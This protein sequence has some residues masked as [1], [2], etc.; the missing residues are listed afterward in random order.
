MKKIRPIVISVITFLLVVSSFANISSIAVSQRQTSGTETSTL[1]SYTKNEEIPANEATSTSSEEPEISF[2]EDTEQEA[3]DIKMPEA[4]TGSEQAVNDRFFSRVAGENGSET[5]FRKDDELDVSTNWL[6]VDTQGYNLNIQMNDYTTSAATRQV[7]IDIPYGVMIRRTQLDDIAGSN[8]SPHVINW[9]IKERNPRVINQ[10]DT[11]FNESEFLDSSNEDNPYNTSYITGS[12]IVIELDP[13]FET[14][15]LS[16]S[17]L[18]NYMDTGHDNRS[19]WSGVENSSLTRGLPLTIEMFEDDTSVEK[20]TLDDIN[21]PS[22]AVASVVTGS[23]PGSGQPNPQTLDTDLSI[24]NQ[25]RLRRT[26]ESLGRNAYYMSNVSWQAYVPYK[27]LGDG[28]YVSAILDGTRMQAWI[29]RLTAAN[30]KPVLTYSTETQADGR[31]IVNYSFADTSQEYLLLV[32]QL[33]MHYKLPSEA[34]EPDPSKNFSTSDK[35]LFTGENLGWDF[36]NYQADEDGN[37]NMERNQVWTLGDSTISVSIKGENMP[38]DFAN[39]NPNGISGSWVSTL[40]NTKGQ[41]NLLGFNLIK[42]TTSGSGT[43]EVNYEFGTGTPWR[44]GVT[45]VQFWTVNT[46]YGGS[47]ASAREYPYNF[48]FKLQ[49]KGSSAGQ[50]VLEGEYTLIPSQEYAGVNISR[51]YSHSV[52]GNVNSKEVE[53]LL[54]YPDERGFYYVNREMLIKGL[55]EVPGDIDDYYIKS[56]TY[57]LAITPTR[58]GGNYTSGSDGQPR[59]NGGNFFGETFQTAGGNGRPLTTFSIKGIEGTESNEYVNDGIRTQIITDS[60]VANQADVSLGINDMTVKNDEDRLLTTTNDR[61]AVGERVNVAAQAFHYF[62]PYAYGQYSPDPVFI[63]RTPVDMDL[64]PSTIGLTQDGEALTYDLS[65]P[66]LL[67]EN[68]VNGKVYLVTPQTEKGI[69]YYNE[70]RETIGNNIKINYQ[71]QVNISARAE[72]INY[73]ELLFITDKNL[74][75]GYAGQ[76]LATMV[77]DRWGVGEAISTAETAEKT[78]LAKIFYYSNNDPSQ[79]GYR[80]SGANNSGNYMFNTVQAELD[81]GLRTDL[82]EEVPED[83]AGIGMLDSNETAFDMNF[84]MN[85]T[86]QPGYVVSPTGRFFYY[87]PIPKTTADANLP[88]W[89]DSQQTSQYSLKLNGEVSIESSANVNYQVY[90]STDKNLLYN[91]GDTSIGGSASVARYVPYEDVQNNL[92]DVTMVKVVAEVRGANN[93]LV[94]YGEQ[95]TASLPVIYDGSKTEFDTK[96]KEL[97]SWQPYLIQRYTLDGATNEFRNIAPVKQVRI[98]YRE[99]FERDIYAFNETDYPNWQTENT[100]RIQTVDL[101]DFEN[102]TGSNLQIKSVET[103]SN[104]DLETKNTISNNLNNGVTYGNRT[105]A[106]DN[107]FSGGSIEELASIN[108][109]TSIGNISQTGNQLNYEIFNT[110]NINNVLDA[111]KVTITYQSK[112]SDDLEFQVVLNIRR[113]LSKITPETALVAGK[114]YSTITPGDATTT[115]EDGAFTVQFAYD[116]TGVNENNVGA[117]IGNDTFLSFNKSDGST[118]AEVNLPAGATILMKN[119]SRKDGEPIDPIY[120]YYRNDT[121]SPLT[122]VDLT[123]FI[124]TGT[125]NETLTIADMKNWAVDYDQ[126][127][128]LFIIDFGQGNAPITTSDNY[129]SLEFATSAAYESPS[130][131]IN[132]ERIFT[133]NQTEFPPVSV[134]QNEALNLGGS[135]DVND[136][137]GSVDAFNTDKSVAMVIDLTSAMNGDTVNWPQGTLLTDSE[138]EI[139]ETRR[140]GNQLIFIYPLGDLTNAGAL[141][142]YNFKITTPVDPLPVGF[143]NLNLQIKTNYEGDYPLNGKVVNTISG[144]FMIAQQPSTGL[145][146]T[147]NLN[148]RLLYN[149]SS[150]RDITLNYSKTN[151]S[152]VTAEVQVKNGSQYKVVEDA[153]RDQ[154]FANLNPILGAD[155]GSWNIQIANDLA[156]SLNGEYQIVFNAYQNEADTE[157]LYQVPWTFMIWDPPEN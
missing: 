27:D 78:D 15:G 156:Q 44:M 145:R 5:Y 157:P 107:G 109:I 101:P 149:S 94:P 76:N 127:S 71:M 128:Y 131:N 7:E 108:G 133:H 85:N 136:V 59:N 103:T 102:L 72:A 9:S 86:S 69:G 117:A 152:K 8:A 123:K 31:V 99:I 58:G 126:L 56:L 132:S 104:V 89:Y 63:I 13:S 19:Y 113:R 10:M 77:P 55:D 106:I 65:D 21:M 33:E 81:F 17:L 47:I 144:A 91:S 26:N 125:T 68:G 142:E 34:K 66:I 46:D 50:N 84:S 111:R 1:N 92:A 119:Q 141:F 75:S 53:P 74:A 22:P 130:Y 16:L 42:E 12:K 100:P 61:V 155:T 98:R 118:S 4:K 116:V 73:Q 95:M 3:A 35:I 41:Q 105:F 83:D 124:R 135:L 70:D 79:T 39:L 151:I 6:G 29:D 147:S 110:N 82:S 93:T 60:F 96:A 37:M 154:I 2:E 28:T 122:K 30:G 40:T 45:T 80:L 20:R 153:V 11:T 115:L 24:Y 25:T 51:N 54:G 38:L 67:G 137:T 129:I 134:Q 120:Y 49:K 90:Y 138:G 150:V 87:L 62:Y 114:E 146:V 97:T 43:A 57:D 140:V 18:P 64:L 88:E 32:N 23:T 148:D 139:I 14:A 121:G 52:V 143:Y 112:D 48:K 36:G